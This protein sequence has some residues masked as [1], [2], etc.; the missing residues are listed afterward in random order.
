MPILLPQRLAQSLISWSRMG[1]SSNTTNVSRS[2]IFEFRILE[3]T[4][5]IVTATIA[6]L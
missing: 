5:P 2:S 3:N 4:P 6:R 1:Q